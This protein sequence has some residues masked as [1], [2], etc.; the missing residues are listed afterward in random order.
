MPIGLTRTIVRSIVDGT[1]ATVPTRVDPLW[2]FAV[3]RRAPEAPDAPLEPRA[4]WTDP[5]AFDVAN[6]RLAADV[7]ANF[8]Q[9]A[10]EVPAEVLAAGPQLPAT[11]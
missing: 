6:W 11:P 2:G 1:L 10:A 4:T 8:E 9:F 5:A 7:I 3:P